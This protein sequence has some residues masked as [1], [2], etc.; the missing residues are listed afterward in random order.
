MEIYEIDQID[1]G[2]KVLT[3]CGNTLAD[4]LDNAVYVYGED[5][6]QESPACDEDAVDYIKEWYRLH[7]CPEI[8]PKHEPDAMTL[9]KDYVMD[10]ILNA[11][12]E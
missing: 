12:W 6:D 2:N 11:D 3:S 1:L 9:A 7:K 10:Q 5:M 4:L 8:E